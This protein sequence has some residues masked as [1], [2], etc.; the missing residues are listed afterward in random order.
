M[1][2]KFHCTFSL[3]EITYRSVDRIF[4]GLVIAEKTLE[5]HEWPYWYIKFQFNKK[6]FE[7]YAVHSLT[8]KHILSPLPMV[9]K[10]CMSKIDLRLETQL[11]L[12]SSLGHCMRYLASEPGDLSVSMNRSA[13]SG[14]LGSI[15]IWLV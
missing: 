8:H 12:T 6:N 14:T 13:S 5:A 15:T 7:I 3:T 9:K 11:F 10:P 1:V 4:V 2:A